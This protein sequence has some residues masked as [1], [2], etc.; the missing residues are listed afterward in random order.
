MFGT[1]TG[2]GAGRVVACGEWS[3]APPS[4]NGRPTTT[5][6]R[7]QTPPVRG[8]KPSAACSCRCSRHSI[9]PAGAAEGDPMQ[10]WT[11]RIVS[12]PALPS[13]G[14]GSTLPPSFPA[15]LSCSPVPAPHYL[16][17][18]SGTSEGDPGD[19]SLGIFLRP[20]RALWS[21]L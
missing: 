13:S 9:R 6:R 1:A 3:P 10:V 8:A 2:S 16:I 7:G 19:T 11:P 4:L 17:L 20:L 5:L 14:P 21:V 18:R 15:P 12:L